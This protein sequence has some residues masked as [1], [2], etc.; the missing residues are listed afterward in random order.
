VTCASALRVVVILCTCVFGVLGCAPQVEL[1]L[2]RGE[3]LEIAPSFIR[4][5]V[6]PD[7]A[8]RSLEYGPYTLTAVPAEEFADVPI[9]TLFYVDVFGC[10][11]QVADNC[12]E[13][14]EYTAR[15]CSPFVE[16]ERDED[17]ELR[18]EIFP[19]DVGN[20]RCP[21]APP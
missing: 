1:V 12:N 20:Q 18:I 11:D 15:G 9:G 3:G 21:P 19:P 4:L 14:I 2:V 6:R 16:R 10:G 17:L 7:G 8:E 13:E 5:L